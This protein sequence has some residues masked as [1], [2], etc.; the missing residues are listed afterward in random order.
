MRS[1]GDQRT[2]T[3]GNRIFG[4]HVHYDRYSAGPH[5]LD[6]V[7]RGQQVTTRRIQLDDQDLRVPLLR[8]LDAAFDVVEH[9]RH[10]RTIRGHDQGKRL[11]T[12]G[13]DRLEDCQ[14]GGKQD[15]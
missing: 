9:G 2:G 5:G 15:Q 12:L 10:D 6:N 7:E 3:P 13:V 4:C 8:C 11:V 14:Q 1:Y